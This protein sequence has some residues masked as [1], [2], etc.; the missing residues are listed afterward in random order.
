[1]GITTYSEFAY[2][3]INRL[4]SHAT[5]NVATYDVEK[6]FYDIIK[7]SHLDRFNRI[8]EEETKKAALRAASYLT[9]L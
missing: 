8:D 9:F 5:L 3:K 2:I 1:M 6:P 4:H 7:P